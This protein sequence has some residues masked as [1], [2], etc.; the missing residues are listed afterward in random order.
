MNSVRRLFVAAA[1][2][3]ALVGTVALAADA[4]VTGEWTMSVE[5]P[6][7]TGSPHFS[8]KQE[9]T[10]VTGHYKGQLGEAAVTGTVS[11]NEVTLKYTVEGQG[12]S[13]TVVYSGTVDGDTMKG[14]V[15][16]GD[17]GDGTFT[18]KKD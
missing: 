8:L 12:Q 7:G 4:N 16:L 18:G 15:S 1:A 2:A 9:G 6:A 11:G 13:V 10:N 5:T 3:F 14:K 17:F